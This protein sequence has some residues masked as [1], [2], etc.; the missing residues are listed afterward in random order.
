[1]LAVVGNANRTLAM[2]TRLGLAHIV[3]TRYRRGRSGVA[4]PSQWHSTIC[5]L[6]IIKIHLLD[7]FEP[8]L[9]LAL[10]C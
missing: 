3:S 1:M 4:L 8:F 10:D 5:R 9:E 6:S 7:L 2:F